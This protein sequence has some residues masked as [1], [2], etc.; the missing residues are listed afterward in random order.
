MTGPNEALAVVADPAELGFDSVR[1][2]RIDDLLRRYVD[3]GKL[4]GWSVLVSRCGQ[5][6][7]LAR[8]GLRDIEAGGFSASIR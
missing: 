4:P 7:H 6:V 1:L 2:G 3:D 5:P 8:G